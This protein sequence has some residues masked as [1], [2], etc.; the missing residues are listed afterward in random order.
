M[1]EKQKL[2]ILL[3][4]LPVVITSK[5]DKKAQA[6]WC[7]TKRTKAASTQSFRLHYCYSIS[8]EEWSSMIISEEGLIKNLNGLDLIDYFDA[9]EKKGKHKC[10]CDLFTVLMVTGCVCGG[11]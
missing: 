9:S 7:V 2:N 10:T 11:K 5:L 8:L 3:R 6:I 1:D 4:G